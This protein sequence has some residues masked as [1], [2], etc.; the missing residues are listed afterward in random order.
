M[1]FIFLVKYR[2]YVVE[3]ELSNYALEDEL[4]TYQEHD[5]KCL[6][7]QKFRCE[8]VEIMNQLSHLRHFEKYYT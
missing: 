7:I 8:K 5:F 1:L 2:N 6:D 3:D 4:F